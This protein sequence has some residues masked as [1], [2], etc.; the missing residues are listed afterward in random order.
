MWKKPFIN[1]KSLLQQKLL[2]FFFFLSLLPCRSLVP[3]PHFCVSF[4]EPHMRIYGGPEF[5]QH[6]GKCHDIFYCLFGVLGFFCVQRNG[7]CCSQSFWDACNQMN[8]YW[9]ILV[10]HQIAGAEVDME[11]VDSHNL[12]T[13]RAFLIQSSKGSGPSPV[14]VWLCFPNSFGSTCVVL[15]MGT[16]EPKRTGSRIWFTVVK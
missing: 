13:D 5:M 2:F 16:H 15:T 9:T 6:C 3:D 4:Q 1:R 7:I 8:C 12:I 11:F 10:H 14:S